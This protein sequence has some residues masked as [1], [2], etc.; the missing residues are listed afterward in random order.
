MRFLVAVQGSYGDINP[1]VELAIGLQRRGHQICFITSGFYAPLMARH[2]FDF[3]ATLSREEHLR[4]TSHPNF[5]HRYKCYKYSAVEFVF[6]PMRREYQAIA[7]RYQPGKTAVLVLGVTL[8]SRIAHEK[9]GVPLVTIAQFPQWMYSVEEPFGVNGPR[10]L[11][12]WGR[13]LLQSFKRW[14]LTSAAT[15]EAS[16]LCADLGLK[17]FPNG[18]RNWMGSPDLVL[19]LFPEWY[20]NR[21]S[22]WPPNVH[23]TGFPSP[24]A[25]EPTNLPD[26]AE[27]FLNAGDPPLIINS[28]SAFHRAQEFF[29]TSVAAVQS[30]K[31]RAIL[32]SQFAHNVPPNLPPEIRHFTYLPHAALMARGAGIVHQ[33]GIGTTFKALR[34]AIPQLVVPVNFDQPYNA[35]CVETLGVGAMLSTSKYRTERVAQTMGALLNSSRVRERCAF[36]SEKI[37]AHDGVAEA[38]QLIEKVICSRAR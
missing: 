4:I 22:D 13:K 17:P 5:N 12:L 32:L 28:L 21:K 15:P 10:P 24:E 16:R 27:E 25:G 34:A 36:Y 18:F 31:K 38:C 37:R 8:G 7:D 3:H 2:G 23:L 20:A 26:E 14:R 33:G 29:Q 30:M 11:P 19:G 6:K 1:C 9:L 35:M